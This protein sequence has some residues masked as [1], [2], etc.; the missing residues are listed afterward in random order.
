MIMEGLKDMLLELSEFIN[1]H[2]PSKRL[3]YDR[4]EISSD[5]LGYAPASKDQIK[6]KEIELGLNLPS[7]YIEFLLISNGFRQVSNFSGKLYPI[8]KI[9]F[10]KVL[11]PELL[12]AYQDMQEYDEKI[13][14]STL[15]NYNNES[16]TIW[17][18]S[19][20]VDSITISDWGDGTI[21]LLNPNSFN[22]RDY[23]VWEYGNWFPGIVRYKNF[24]HFIAEKLFS[25][26]KLYGKS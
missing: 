14:E 7:S 4:Q 11:H 24:H 8:E 12:E 9:G 19:D 16:C 6:E 18:Y 17:K 5:W 15:R 21:I 13:A 25:T 1:K 2:L 10:T 3:L 20:F 22:R 26:K 23:E